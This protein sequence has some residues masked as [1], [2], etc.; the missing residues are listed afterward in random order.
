[1]KDHALRNQITVRVKK[2]IVK[3][4]NSTERILMQN[5]HP[6]NNKML[7]V[8]NP[9][10]INHGLLAFVVHQNNEVTA[11]SIDSEVKD[12]YRQK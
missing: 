4:S 11:F 12:N 7:T 10:C 2:S 8:P 9:K 1:M 6:C 5:I 3:V